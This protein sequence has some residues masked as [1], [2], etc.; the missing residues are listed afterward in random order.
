MYM[1]DITTQ[2]VYTAHHTEVSGAV[3]GT[4]IIHIEKMV[5]AI[6]ELKA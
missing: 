3:L 2:H 4:E 5:L 1:H 6:K